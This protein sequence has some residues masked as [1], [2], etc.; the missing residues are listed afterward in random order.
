MTELTEKNIIKRKSNEA[1]F[2]RVMCS[3]LRTKKG[4]IRYFLRVCVRYNEHWEKQGGTYVPLKKLIC[5]R[6]C[7]RKKRGDMTYSEFRYL[8]NVREVEK[9]NVARL[10]DIT[11]VMTV[12]K[13]S[14]FRALERL[15]KG[16]YVQKSKDRK[17]YL[18]EKGRGF[19]KEYEQ[20]IFFLKEKMLQFAGIEE[21]TAEEE[22]MRIVCV[23]SDESRG[24]IVRAWQKR[25][26]KL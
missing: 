21:D 7:E 16:G 12:T 3:L 19:L 2:F 13:V 8:W 14:V 6:V 18:T 10:K 17:I 11:N 1:S 25:E 22:A 9:D 15:E 5:V 20:A 23:L 24:K 26:G 4:A